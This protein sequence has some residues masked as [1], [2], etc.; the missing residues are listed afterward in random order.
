MAVCNC[1]FGTKTL[2]FHAFSCAVLKID[3]FNLIFYF[4]MIGRLPVKINMTDWIPKLQDNL[5]CDIDVESLPP[6]IP[7]KIIETPLSHQNVNNNPSAIVLVES[8][9]NPAPA[10]AS[11]KHGKRER[12]R[13]RERERKRKRKQKFGKRSSDLKVSMSDCQLVIRYYTK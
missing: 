13:E 10:W 7:P 2:K 3:F 12:E 11:G 6:P 5:K 8:E 9:L 4:L 1:T